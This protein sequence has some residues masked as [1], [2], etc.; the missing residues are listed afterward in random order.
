[1]FDEKNKYNKD[2]YSVTLNIKLDNI[3]KS[4]KDLKYKVGDNERSLEG[5]GLIIYGLQ[6]PAK[7]AFGDAVQIIKD[8]H[9][10]GTV[11]QKYVVKAEDEEGFKWTGWQYTVAVKETESLRYLMEDKLEL[12]K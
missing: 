11:V 1:M 4:L 8:P 12:K 3:E 7:F 5:H 2:D 10:H 9:I 6:H